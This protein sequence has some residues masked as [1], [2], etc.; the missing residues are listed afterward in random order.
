MCGKTLRIEIIGC[1]GPTFITPAPD[2]KNQKLH[3]NNETDISREVFFI[4]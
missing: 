4:E 3:L 2:T 1:I